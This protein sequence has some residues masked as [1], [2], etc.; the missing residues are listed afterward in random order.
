MQQAAP[1]LKVKVTQ[2]RGKIKIKDPDD[3]DELEDS[4]PLEEVLLDD[5]P[6]LDLPEVAVDTPGVLRTQLQDHGQPRTASSI[7]PGTWG[8]PASAVSTSGTPSGRGLST[9]G[10]GL[11]TRLFTR[12]REASSVRASTPSATSCSSLSWSFLGAALTRRAGSS[13][14]L[15]AAVDLRQGG[16]LCPAF[17]L[18]NVLPKCNYSHFTKILPQYNYS[19]FPTS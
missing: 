9:R 14:F 1:T 10:R 3:D 11:S 12:G 6:G 2:Q 16:N 13:G 18:V 5:E 7:T 4:L 19:H 17:E 8:F 15:A